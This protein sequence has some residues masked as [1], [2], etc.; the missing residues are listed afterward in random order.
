MKKSTQELMIA[1]TI[2]QVFEWVKTGHWDKATFTEWVEACKQD[3]YDTGW[4]TS[5]ESCYDNSDD[6]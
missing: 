5:Q 2:Q 3:S 4:D 1:V 6:N